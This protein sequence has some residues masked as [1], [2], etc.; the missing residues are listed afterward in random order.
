MGAEQDRG[1]P[2]HYEVRLLLTTKREGVPD[3]ARVAALRGAV[4]N[5]PV[6]GAFT[7]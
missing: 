7:R 1:L 5:K 3:A 2:L 4:R 6:P